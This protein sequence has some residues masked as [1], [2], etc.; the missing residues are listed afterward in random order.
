MRVY[1]V[2]SPA[3]LNETTAALEA[4]PQMRVVGAA[5]SGPAAVQMVRD[6]R[7]DVAVVDDEMDD[8]LG[9]VERLVRVTDG[10]VV[11]VASDHPTLN[12]MRQAVARGGADI[13]P[14]PVT[15]LGLAGAVQRAQGGGQRQAPPPPEG[16]ADSGPAQAPPAQAAAAL[17]PQLVAVHSPKGGVGTTT[18]ALNL[19][20]AFRA[21]GGKVI[22]ADF[23]GYGTLAAALYLSGTASVADWLRVA[24]GLPSRADLDALTCTHTSGIRVI[25]APRSLADAGVLDAETARTIL[26]AARQHSDVVIVDCG[27]EVLDPQLVALEQA[28]RVYEVASLD[29]Q[30]LWSL[31]N[32][33]YLLAALG[34]DM[35]PIMTVLNRVPAKPDLPL[36]Q[37]R[38]LLPWP[39]AAEIPEDPAVPVATN[40]QEIVTLTRPDSP[41]AAAV[42]R[43]AG[44]PDRAP[45]QAGRGMI[46]RLLKWG[47]AVRH[48]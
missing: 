13:V 37:V 21:A 36:R 4:H 14:K 34:L 3:F 16:G 6:L 18:L 42:H 20:G 19:A 33:R 41:F 45:R 47:G 29:T 28:T 9:L 39:L 35:A 1:L 30:A 46:G 40:R 11:V 15:P 22:L 27:K 7:P 44:L 38:E 17:R 23:S 31:S 24:G 12:L 32:L 2:G 25:P 8:A 26:A 5:S 48:G 43:L 10:L